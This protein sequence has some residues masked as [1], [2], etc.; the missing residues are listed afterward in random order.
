MACRASTARSSRLRWYLAP[1]T[2]SL[3]SALEPAVALSAFLRP[4]AQLVR[5][6]AHLALTLCG[7]PLAGVGGAVVPPLEDSLARSTG[8]L[9]FRIDI[10][11]LALQEMASPADPVA[12]SGCLAHRHTRGLT[13]GSHRAED[14][15]NR[16]MGRPP[17]LHPEPLLLVTTPRL[18]AWRAARP[19][20]LRAKP[21]D[22]LLASPGHLLRLRW[23][24][25]TINP[26]VSTHRAVL[27]VVSLHRPTIRG[28]TPKPAV[29]GRGTPVAY[30]AAFGWSGAR[31]PADP[32]AA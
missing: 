15:P 6:P 5:P 29:G 21:T 27:G 11:V 31:S 9:A 7:D 10:Q 28:V 22:D 25:H 12:S 16:C 1:S 14:L 2:P 23:I 13:R 4:M 32:R 17:P 18:V 20:V 8:A 24:P 30:S 19:H 26:N 3:P